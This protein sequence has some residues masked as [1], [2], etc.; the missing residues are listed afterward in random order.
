LRIFDRNP[1]DRSSHRAA[2]YFQVFIVHFYTVRRQPNP[3]R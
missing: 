2:T 3:C 1:R